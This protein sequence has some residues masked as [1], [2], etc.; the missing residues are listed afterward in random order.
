[1]KLRDKIKLTGITCAWEE[2][3]IVCEDF[4]NNFRE[5]P[6]DIKIAR[7]IELAKYVLSQEGRK[8]SYEEKR[9]RKRRPQKSTCWVCRKKPYCQ[10]HII[11]LR[12]G[13]FDTR[14]NRIDIC[15]E[16]HKKIHPWLL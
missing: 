16:C 15:E 8:I 4:K 14:N 5:A 10:H 2:S 13:G 1:M 6:I 7:L 11:L 3:Y 12:N 9:K